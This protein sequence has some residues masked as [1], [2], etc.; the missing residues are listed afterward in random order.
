MIYGIDLDL[1]LAGTQARLLSANGDVAT[2]EV[3]YPLL[4]KTIRFEMQLL[5]RD[6]R[7]YSADAVRDAEA[8]LLKPLIEGEPSRQ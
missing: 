7:W 3:S 6:G 8:E 2:M 5:R 1:A 4:G